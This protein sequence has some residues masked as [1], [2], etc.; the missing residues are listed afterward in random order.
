MEF[1]TKDIT[2]R[3][4]QLRQ[5]MKLN[6]NLFAEKISVHSKQLAKYETNRSTPSLSVLARIARYCEVST[7]Y[8]IFGEDEY[9]IKRT[10]I[11]DR[12]LLDMFRIVNNLAKADRDKVKWGLKSLLGGVQE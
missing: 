7:D 4:K 8:L 11:N 1:Q 12:E 9:V 2:K 5:S 3:I 6:Q 10:K